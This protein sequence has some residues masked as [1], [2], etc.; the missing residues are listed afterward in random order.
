MLWR[1]DDELFGSR[2]GLFEVDSN[3]REIEHRAQTIDC[4]A[5]RTSLEIF[6]QGLVGD[7]FDVA[8][9]S[10]RRSVLRADH[11]NQTHDLHLSNISVKLCTIDCEIRLI[12]L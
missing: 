4:G 10:P 3:D 9:P 12:G 11:D 2:N 6:R 8:T 1:I 5:G 7:R